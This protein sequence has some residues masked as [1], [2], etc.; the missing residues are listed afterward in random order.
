MTKGKY[1][2]GRSEKARYVGLSCVCV[3]CA[4]PYIL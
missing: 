2:Y 3:W 1:G 4:M